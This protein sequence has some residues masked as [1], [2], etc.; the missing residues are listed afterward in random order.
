[1]STPKRRWISASLVAGA[2]AL[3]VVGG[4]AALTLPANASAT[5]SV[6]TPAPQMTGPDATDNGSDGETADD[7]VGEVPGQETA[8]DPGHEDGT[9]DGETADDAPTG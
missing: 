7:Q 4:V 8:D 9:A 3:A 1:M 5:T 2:L 6:S